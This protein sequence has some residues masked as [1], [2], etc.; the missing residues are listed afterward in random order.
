[1]RASLPV[2]V[3][4]MLSLTAVGGCGLKDDLYLPAE[5]DA[6]QP[7]EQPEDDAEDSRT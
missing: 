2:V 5:T 1:M 3:V 6:P 7:A 4:L